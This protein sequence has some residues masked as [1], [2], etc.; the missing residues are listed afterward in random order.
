[1]NEELVL[2]TEELRKYPPDREW[3][4]PVGNL[5]SEAKAAVPDLI[6]VLK[7]EIRNARPQAARALRNIGDTSAVPALIEALKDESS[8][9]RMSAAG[10]LGGKGK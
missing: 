8:S 9:V 7:D 4:I 5:G 2:A 6:E 3:F 10:A 1:M